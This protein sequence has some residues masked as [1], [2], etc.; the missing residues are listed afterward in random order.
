M[1]CY[2]FSYLPPGL[3]RRADISLFV[4]WKTINKY[5]FFFP[6]AALPPGL[7]AGL[8]F[9]NLNI[10]TWERRTTEQKQKKNKLRHSFLSSDKKKQFT[11]KRTYITTHHYTR[12]PNL[13]NKKKKK[14]TLFLLFYEQNPASYPRCSTTLSLSLSLDKNE[15]AT[16]QKTGIQPLHILHYCCRA[17]VQGLL[18]HW[19]VSLF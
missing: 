3:L 1:S 17:V 15:T 5:F 7:S 2:N 6:L 12:N 18:S 4:S 16:K 11:Q 13:Q 10:L 8:S 19:I 9:G 14:K